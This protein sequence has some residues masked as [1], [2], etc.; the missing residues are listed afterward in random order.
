MKLRLV[1]SACLLG[2][3]TLAGCSDGKTD[4]SEERLK[5]MAGGE[6]KEVVPVKGEVN[7]DGAPAEGV[8]LFLYREEDLFNFIKECRTDI[9]GRYCWSTNLSCD[10]LEP[11]KYRIGMTHVPKP[12]KN[13]EGI[14]VFEGK[15]QNPQMNEFQLTVEKGAPQEAMNYDLQSK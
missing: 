11:G 4:L 7:V 6:L 1:S 5:A 15:Y 12:K 2:L 10:G 3:V 8:N 14:D 13:G 9:G